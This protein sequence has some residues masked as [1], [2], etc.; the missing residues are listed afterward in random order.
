[1]VVS[2]FKLTK[3]HFLLPSINLSLLC[4]S[5]GSWWRVWGLS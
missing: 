2:L 4:I 5:I 1:M 3:C